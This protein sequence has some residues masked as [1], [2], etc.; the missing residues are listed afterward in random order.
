MQP[1]KGNVPGHMLCGKCNRILCHDCL[2]GRGMRSHKHRVPNF[3]M[4]NRF[5]LKRVQLEGVLD[6]YD[7]EVKDKTQEKKLHGET[8]FVGHVG[9]ELMEICHRLVHIYD[10]GPV[11]FLDVRT[12]NRTL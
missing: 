7:S 3:Q 1:H 6:R 8:H 2:S 12:A 9:D 4:I 11:P 5:L 10:A